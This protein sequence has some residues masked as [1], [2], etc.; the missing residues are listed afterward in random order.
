MKKKNTETIH[1]RKLSET[2]H[3]KKKKQ[4]SILIPRLDRFACDSMD[5]VFKAHRHYFLKYLILEFV[6]LFEE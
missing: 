4:H 6:C 2:I 5:S 3:I 1:I